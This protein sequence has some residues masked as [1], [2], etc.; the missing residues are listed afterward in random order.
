[1]FVL[2]E[3]ESF[4]QVEGMDFLDGA[5]TLATLDPAEVVSADSPGIDFIERHRLSVVETETLRI[6]LFATNGWRCR[7]FRSYWRTAAFNGATS[8]QR[9]SPHRATQSTS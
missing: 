4:H 1:M 3:I 6:E 7:R 5:P 2:V 8:L 9:A